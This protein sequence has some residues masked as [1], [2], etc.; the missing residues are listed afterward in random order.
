MTKYILFV[1][2]EVEDPGKGDPNFGRSKPNGQTTPTEEG[3]RVQQF[4]D[5]RTIIDDLLKDHRVYWEPGLWR[6]GDKLIRSDPIDKMDV[7]VTNC[8]PNELDMP[9]ARGEQD[10]LNYSRSLDCLKAVKKNN[11]EM[12]IIVYTGA[13]KVVRDK[14]RE[15]GVEVLHRERYGL[16]IELDAIRKI[17]KS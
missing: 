8:P 15:L 10:H 6:A 7:L 2:P 14:C 9:W 4:I 3:N 17:I 13:P 1:H 16:K 11:P 12:K 5:N